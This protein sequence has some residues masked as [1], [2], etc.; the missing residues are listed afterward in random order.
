MENNLYGY[1]ATV[2]THTTIYRSCV[3]SI[4]V[5]DQQHVHK[6]DISIIAASC[7]SNEV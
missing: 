4:A 5:E 2:T 7:V 3:K 1:I 6:A